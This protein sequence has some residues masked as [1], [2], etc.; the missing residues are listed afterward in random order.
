[1]ILNCKPTVTATRKEQPIIM[2][3]LQFFKALADETR[4]RLMCVLARYEL[5]V[6]EL[7]CLLGMGQSR[8]SRHLKILADAGLLTPR[9]DGLWVFYSVPSGGE[10]EN[11]WQATLPFMQQDDLFEND[12]RLAAS[13]VQERAVKARQFFNSIAEDWDQMSCDLLG[14]FDLP[15][16]VLASA[17]ICK[18]AA[19]LGCGTGHMLERLLQKAEHVIG[20]DG[21][22]RMLEMARQRFASSPGKVSLRIGELDHLPLA[23][24]EADLVTLS[25]VLHHLERPEA[26]LREISR[27]LKPGGQLL[28]A[29]F[30]KHSQEEL[31]LKYGDRRLG[32]TEEEL[33][34]ILRPLRI[35]K[36]Q[37][38]K[39]ANGLTVLLV[40]ACC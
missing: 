6:N 38:H 32:F 16:T 4:L 8:I 36:T 31:R 15:A 9:R 30:A 20:V 33:G 27:V 18:V 24:G 7:V 35:K 19:D 13:I 17:P 22:P 37:P 5:N 34:Q 25:M 12:C 2:P 10:G 11:F 23:D 21:S 39:L 1:M 28:L 14:D 26:A 3:A 29:D 40:Q